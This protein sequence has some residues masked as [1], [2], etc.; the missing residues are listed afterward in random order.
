MGNGGLR[1]FYFA[2][3][4]RGLIYSNSN[5]TALFDEMILTSADSTYAPKILVGEGI[6]QYPMPKDPST[7]AYYYTPKSFVGTVYYEK[8]CPSL[9]PSI[10]ASPTEPP[11]LPSQLPPAQP[12][13]QLSGQPSSVPSEMPSSIPSSS[14]TIF[15]RKIA[16][17]LLTQIT[18]DCTPGEDFPKEESDLIASA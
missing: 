4:T 13:L 7:Q 1:S 5:D 12:S 2:T 14:P 8:E 9:A 6:L 10:S 16:G 3:K 17:G 11:I 15:T 18:M